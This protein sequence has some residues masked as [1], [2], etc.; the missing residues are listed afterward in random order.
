MRTTI[1]RVWP[2]ASFAGQRFWD[3]VK[4]MSSTK[5]EQL[6]ENGER[7]EPY[8]LRLG[9]EYRV[10]QRLRL[11]CLPEL[12]WMLLPQLDAGRVRWDFF[13][14]QSFGHDLLLD[15]REI[16]DEPCHS[17]LLHVG[18]VIAQLQ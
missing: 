9:S 1:V 14:L 12:D 3:F 4:A 16:L 2:L 15:S 8:S 10:A 13:P 5:P 17:V 11:S 7:Q 6:E 18:P